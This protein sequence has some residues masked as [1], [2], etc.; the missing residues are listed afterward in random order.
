[1][2]TDPWGLNNL[3]FNAAADYITFKGTVSTPPKQIAVMPSY[4]QKAWEENG[5]KYYPYKMKG[6]LDFFYNVSSAVYDVNHEV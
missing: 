4:L 5:R 3:L 2:Q 1:V 6:E